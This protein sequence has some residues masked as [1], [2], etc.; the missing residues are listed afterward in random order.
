MLSRILTHAALR[1][2]LVRINS[3][4]T[5]N[6]KA[7]PAEA[8]E[9]VSTGSFTNGEHGLQIRIFQSSVSDTGCLIACLGMW[10]YSH[11]FGF[12]SF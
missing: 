1:S 8:A 12:F 10:Y 11:V 5:P 9:A 7:K 2:F 4:A 3:E 6:Y